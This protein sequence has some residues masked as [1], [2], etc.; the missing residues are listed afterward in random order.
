[1]I[2][3][4]KI[5][6]FYTAPMSICS[7]MRY[8]NKIPARYDLSSLRVLGPVGKPINPEVWWWY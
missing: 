8:G 5:N 4:H 2:Q 3:R 7:L 6:V 1:M